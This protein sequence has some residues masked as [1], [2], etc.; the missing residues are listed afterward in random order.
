MADSQASLLVSIIIATFRRPD[1]L[2]DALASVRKLQVRDGLRYELLVIDNDSQGTA[3]SLVGSFACNWP[4]GGTLRYVHEPQ[5]GTSFA[6][7]RG[8]NEAAG[9]IVALLDDDIFLD[10]KWLL[11]IVD[12][13]DRTG[14]DCVSG[15]TSVWWE[16]E[17]EALV[18]ACENN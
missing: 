13:F 8:L 2:G 12:C 6:R 18:R 14:A 1:V 17:P 11:E 16:G 10:P 7:N 9:Q 4:A 5:S 3:H 15:R